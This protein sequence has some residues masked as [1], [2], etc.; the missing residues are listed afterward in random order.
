MSFLTESIETRI[1]GMILSLAREELEKSL[2]NLEKKIKRIIIQRKILLILT[3]SKNKISLRK[4]NDEI[5]KIKQN[6][7]ITEKLLSQLE[8]ICN[9]LDKDLE[10]ALK[11]EI[12]EII[13]LIQSWERINDTF[14]QKNAPK[15]RFSKI[16]SDFKEI[17][18]IES[19][20]DS[21]D[22]LLHIFETLK[23][24]IEDFESKKSDLGKRILNY[25]K[26]FSDKE[27]VEQLVDG[28]SLPIKQ[29]TPSMYKQLYSSNLKDKIIIS[30]K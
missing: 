25:W 6:K 18:R 26:D 17:M 10:F 30:L 1:K 13:K 23:Q 3:S 20:L 5:E 14:N 8:E 11:S 7:K 22:D 28:K 16:I 27:F 29:L 21:D 4:V 24:N 15:E 2:K 9:L 19:I 12:Q